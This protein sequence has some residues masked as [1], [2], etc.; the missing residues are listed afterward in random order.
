MA[1]S[2]TAQGA[3]DDSLFGGKEKKILCSKA[4]GVSSF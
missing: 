3:V 4:R 1:G 2:G